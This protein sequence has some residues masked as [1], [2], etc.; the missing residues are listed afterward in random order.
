MVAD[1]LAHPQ[2]NDRLNRTFLSGIIKNLEAANDR[3]ETAGVQ[4][5]MGGIYLAKGNVPSAV[6]HLERALAL[7]PQNAAT[8][9]Q[10]SRAYLL[11]SRRDAA[12]RTVDRLLEID[13][14]HAEG[15][16]LRDWLAQN[17]APTDP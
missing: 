6:D 12:G 5:M 14:A 9:Y 2:S 16:Q 4:Y 1:A 10:L 17:P 15:R 7:E 13:P 11:Q 3:E 8:L